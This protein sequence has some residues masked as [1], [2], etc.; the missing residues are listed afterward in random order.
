AIDPSRKLNNG[1]PGS[2]AMWMDA[3]ELHS[4]DRVLHVGAGTGYYSAILAETVG[5]AGCVLAVEVDSELA[6]MAKVNLASTRHVE[7]VCADGWHFDAGRWDAIMITAGVTHLN[8]RWLDN[9]AP[10]GRLV[11]PL[12]IT[13][14]GMALSAGMMLKVKRIDA[15]Y[16]ARFLSQVSIFPCSSG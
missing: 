11:A 15:G 9:L 16:E 12:T 3:L 4:G 7:V 14:P 10:G 13:M 5:T 6:E 2:L 1:Q 8:R